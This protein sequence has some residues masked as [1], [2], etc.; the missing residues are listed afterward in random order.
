[1][2]VCKKHEIHFISDEIYAFSVFNSAE[3][4]APFKRLVLDSQFFNVLFT[5]YH[6]VLSMENLPDPQRV[7]FVWGL[8][9]DFGLAS[10]RFG[11]VHS[12]NQDLLKV[13]NI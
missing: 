10:F 13:E 6:S 8:S 5:F 11:V 1:M 12:L 3:N 7:H 2:E 9:K 4:D